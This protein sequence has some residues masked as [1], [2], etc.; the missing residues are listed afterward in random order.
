MNVT[1]PGSSFNPRAIEPKPVMVKQEPAAP[2]AQQGMESQTPSSASSGSGITGFKGDFSTSLKEKMESTETSET[3]TDEP[4]TES[5]EG[6][7][8]SADLSSDNELPAERA[9]SPDELDKP[10]DEQNSRRWRQFDQMEAHYS[11]RFL[12][13]N[14]LLDQLSITRD[15]LTQ[16][17]KEMPNSFEASYYSRG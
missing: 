8:E 5:G 6:L 10:A 2:Q 1:G 4:V 3:Q 16:L 9:E 7:E 13:I 17:L 14:Q 12:T 11:A 15:N